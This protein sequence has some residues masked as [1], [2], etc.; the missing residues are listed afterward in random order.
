LRGEG[1]GEGLFSE[2]GQKRFENPVEIIEDLVVP[3]AD[4]AIAKGA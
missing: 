3:D 4:H 1:R 2:F